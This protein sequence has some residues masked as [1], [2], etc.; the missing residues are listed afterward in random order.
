MLIQRQRSRINLPQSDG[1]IAH[2]QLFGQQRREACVRQAL[3]HQ[4]SQNRI[5]ET[6][7]T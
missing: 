1:G 2:R 4:T 5:E 6:P 3:H 7:T